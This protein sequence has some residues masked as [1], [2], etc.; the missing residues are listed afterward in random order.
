MT[1]LTYI[2]IVAIGAGVLDFTLNRLVRL[3]NS[4]YRIALLA[5]Y[6]LFVIRYYYGADIYNYVPIYEHL[7]PWTWYLANPDKY[8]FEHGFVI[9]CAILKGWG[10]SYYW[11][12]AIVTTF[13]FVTLAL[14][15][16]Q[17]KSHKAIALMIVVLFDFNLIFATHRQS[18]AVSFFILMV[19]AM[20]NRKYIWALLL[21]YIITTMH[22]SGIFVVSIVW[23]YYLVHTQHMSRTFVGLLLM[24]LAAMLVLPM[25]SI[26]TAFINHLPLPE[27][28]R[29]SLSVHLSLGRQLQSVWVIYAMTL[30][31]LEYYFQNRKD[32]KMGTE[33][34]VILG[35]ICIVLMYQY[36]FL[37]IRMRSYFMPFLLVYL[38]NSVHEAEE[39]ETLPF[40]GFRLTRDFCLVA[41]FAYFSW[42]TVRFETNVRMMKERAY[43][44]KALT[45]YSPSTVFDLLHRPANDIKTDRLLIAKYYWWYDYMKGEQNKVGGE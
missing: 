42:S 20:D 19:L 14:L 34:V 2:F 1:L 4:V 3:Q 44:P 37:L 7:H 13:Y 32:V 18:L 9:F 35:L 23:L 31:C 10:L 40:A 11:M 8:P 15:F 24:V 5:I 38:F 29:L 39:A 21:A 43:T 26:G 6:F 22:K 28:F 33:V 45:I 27:S 16:R 25:T 12:T 17:I 36:Y 30:V 41:L